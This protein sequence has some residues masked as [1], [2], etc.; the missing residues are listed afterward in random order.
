[1]LIFCFREVYNVI[2]LRLGPTAHIPGDSV[3]ALFNDMQLY[4]SKAQGKKININEVQIF[5]LTF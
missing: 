2:C 4:P 3:Q 5:I 1:M